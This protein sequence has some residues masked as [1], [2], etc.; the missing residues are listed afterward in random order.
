[1]TAVRRVDAMRRADRRVSAVL[2][3]DERCLVLSLG[4]TTREGPV[5]RVLEKV[6]EDVDA[7]LARIPHLVKK[8]FAE[9]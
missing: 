3:R 8:L 2:A 1:M 9:E 5:R 7:R 4:I 6:P